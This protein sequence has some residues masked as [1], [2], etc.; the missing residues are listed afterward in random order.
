MAVHQLVLRLSDDDPIGAAAVNLRIQLR[1]IG[2]AG[3]IYAAAIG[4]G[5][6]ALA[7]PISELKARPTD[8]V[9]Y[10]HSVG[11]TMTALLVHL[12]C[13]RG[14]VLHDPRGASAERVA[15]GREQLERLAG[16]VDVAIAAREDDVPRLQAMGFRRVHLVP[17]VSPRDRAAATDGE[18]RLRAA[19]ADVLPARPSALRPPP[20]KP[21]VGL[22]VQRF[23]E[24]SGGAE[25]HAEMLAQHLAP[26]VD[27]TVLTTC[28]RDHLT[29]ENVFPAGLQYVGPF[30]VLRFPTSQPRQMRPFNALS[31]RLFGRAPSL[32]QQE[33][34]VAAQGPLVPGLLEHLEDEETAY[35]A[36]IGFTYL[37]TPMAWGLPLIASKALVVPTAHDEPPLA[38]DVY[39]DVFSRPQALLCNTPEEVTL[40][41]RRFPHHA[42]TRVVGVGVDSAAADPSRFARKYGQSRSYVF[43]VGRIEAGKG[44]PDLLRHHA[45]LTK[46]DPAAPDLL[47]AG[48]A[49]MRVSGK[50]VRHLG[51]ISDEDKFDGIAG[52]LAV[53]VPSRLESLSLLALEAFAQGTPVIGNQASD[54]L[55]GQIRRS[56][57]G[58]TFRDGASFS[59]AVNAAVAHRASWSKRGRA[60]AAKHSWEAVLGI[61]REEIRRIAAGPA[62]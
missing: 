46:S 51:R 47:L 54:V 19:L 26:E 28:A 42:R 34:W 59:E 17:P 44:I 50:R 12:P 6:E 15:Q 58:A 21:R 31:R 3:D 23:G 40:I 27:L 1:R 22:I 35:D 7:R 37:Y 53:V 45:A 14:V 32:L 5:F 48:E 57:A 62:A 24:V 61:Y 52:A 36:F 11:S 55:A 30:R 18:A 43:Y 56:G 10:H 25:K 9:L 38:F 49:S 2:H 20:A 29:W 39:D 60:F 4:P 16:R 41:E 33:R 13:K 8:L